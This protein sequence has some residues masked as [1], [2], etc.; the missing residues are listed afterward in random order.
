MRRITIDPVLDIETLEWLPRPSFYVED[1][2]VPMLFDRSIKASANQQADANQGNA[3][4]ENATASQIGS[5]IIP[6]LESEA[7]H[8]VGLT[9][10]QKNNQITAGS[11][12]IGGVNSGITGDANLAA[13]RTRNAG[14]F[15]G[16]LDDAARIKSRQQ[17]SNALGVNAEDAAL[18]NEKQMSAQK[19]LGGL[20][21]TDTSAG[22]S[23]MGIAAKNLDTAVDA[24]KT[25]WVQNMDQ[26]LSALNSGGKASGGGSNPVNYV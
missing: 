22:V 2:D 17:S 3:G 12:A 18:A 25:G 26:T 1:K 11:Q 5:S 15:T 10:T 6:G 20:Y 14:G 4:Q 7:N 8:P 21:G 24:D 23:D 9:T 13:A 16:A 19:E